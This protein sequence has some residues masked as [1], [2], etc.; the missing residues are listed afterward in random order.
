M[1][2]IAILYEKGWGVTKNNATAVTWYRRAAEQGDK[3]AE[4]WLKR[5]AKR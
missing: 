4:N 3:A 5:Y 2:D 1:R